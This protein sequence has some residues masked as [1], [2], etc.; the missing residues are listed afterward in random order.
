MNTAKILKF[1]LLGLVLISF[2]TLNSCKDDPVTNNTPTPTKNMLEVLSEAKYSIFK[3]IVDKAN[4]SSVFSGTV[5]YTVFAP[6]DD[7]L[8]AAGIMNADGMT[9]TE[10]ENFVKYHMIEG[11]HTT[12]TLPLYGYVNTLNTQGPSGL[13]PKLNI[14][15]SSETIY[16]NNKQVLATTKGTNGIIHEL[17]GVLKPLTV[18]EMIFS[19]SDLSK[20]RAGLD[21]EAGINAPL[22]DVA[23]LT[24]VFAVNNAGT[25]A[26]TKA[27]ERQFS[28]MNPTDRRAFLNNGI[29]ASTNKLAAGITAGSLSTQGD[30]LNV[31]LSA[32]KIILNDTVTVTITD[33]QCIN[34][35]LHIVDKALSK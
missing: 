33:V 32:G 28:S 14:R 12:L 22:K 35:V 6:T 11:E 9:E 15:I 23:A 24:T 21:L 25:D 8:V 17:G 20:Y 29:V 19:S 10:A 3:A 16:A 5:K 4:F 30:P 27:K 2:S 34:G 13:K 31:T 1:S 18:Y 7:Q 26:F